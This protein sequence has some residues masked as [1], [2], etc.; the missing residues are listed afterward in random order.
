MESM[1]GA[2]H[3]DVGLKHFK[4]GSICRKLD[5]LAEA[6]EHFEQAIAALDRENVLIRPELLNALVQL[7]Q[8]RIL[9]STMC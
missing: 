3:T 6:G 4:M 1:F 5:M 8:V 2:H 7:G 9:C